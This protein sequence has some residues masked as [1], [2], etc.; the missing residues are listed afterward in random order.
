MGKLLEEVE[1][2]WDD[3]EEGLGSKIADFCRGYQ[4]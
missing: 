4:W 3:S 2:D 1:A